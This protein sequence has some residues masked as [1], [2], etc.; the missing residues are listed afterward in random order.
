MAKEPVIADKNGH[1][2]HVKGYVVGED[3]ELEKLFLTRSDTRGKVYAR[4]MV[5]ISIW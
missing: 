3:V 4:T 1:L 2:R 5:V